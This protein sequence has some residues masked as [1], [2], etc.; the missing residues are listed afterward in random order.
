[1]SPLGKYISSVTGGAAV[2][3]SAVVAAAVV[4]V[5]PLLPAE[6]DPQPAAME[7]SMAAANSKDM[8]LFIFLS[9]LFTIIFLFSSFLLGL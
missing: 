6:E 5:L 3:A 9:M 4:W 7:T 1:L 8:D 2:S